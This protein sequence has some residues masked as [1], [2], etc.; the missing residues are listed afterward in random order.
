MIFGIS[1]AGNGFLLFPAFFS[2]F[3]AGN[4]N[5]IAKNFVYQE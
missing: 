1:G 3:V 4:Q 5:K 2:Y